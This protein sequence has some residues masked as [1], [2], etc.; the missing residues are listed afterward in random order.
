MT[1]ETKRFHLF[2]SEY[3][4]R[5]AL[6]AQQNPNPLVHERDCGVFRYHDV[7]KRKAAAVNNSAS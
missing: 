3:Q 1:S 2:W 5:I 7:P 4:R 6:L